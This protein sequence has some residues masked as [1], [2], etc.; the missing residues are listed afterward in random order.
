MYGQTLIHTIRL[1]RTEVGCLIIEIYQ[2]ENMINYK[3]IKNTVVSK[4]FPARMMRTLGYH[5][6]P[7]QHLQWN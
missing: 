3:L 6:R 5:F 2:T 4:S 1:T 7:K